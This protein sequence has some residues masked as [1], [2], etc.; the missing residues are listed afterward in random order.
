MQGNIET[1]IAPAA[2][3]RLDRALAL[4][5][6]VR[7][8]EGATAVL[9]L[10][11]VFL[12]LVCYSVIKTVREPLILLGGGA[13]VRSYAAAGQALL[14]MG[15]VPLYGLVA[16]K[17]SRLKL[18]VGVT[19]F[20][21]ACIELFALAVSARVPYVGVAFFI[22]VGIFN[23]SLV[24][25]FWS[26]ANDIYRREAGDRLFPVIMIGMTAGAPLGSIVA[27]RLF[28]AGLTP[29][30][31]L[32]VSAL[33][34]T[35][36]VGIYFLIN[37][38][39]AGTT[40]A[41]AEPLA[42][43]GGFGLVL[44]NPYLRLV[45]AL[46]VLLNIVNTTGEYVVA[47]LLTA[48]VS[49]LAAAAPG[50][51]KQAFIGAFSG[52][53]QFYVNITALL[54]Q[55]FVT[56][57]LVKF[58]GLQGA[59]LALPLIALGGYSLI[60][61]G[62][63]FTAVRWLKTA[64]NAT[65]YSIMNTARQ[66]LWL[67]T[68]R[69]E[70]YK[71]KQAVD[72]FFVRA[73]DV[74]SAMVVYAGTQL[75][76][77]GPSQF[78][79]V[80]VVLTLAWIG[81]A[82]RLLRPV[83]SRP[84]MAM[85]RLAGVGAAAAVAGVL[86]LATPASA[87]DSRADQLAAQRAEKAANLHPY[88]PTS[89]ERR[90]E[91]L[92][93]QLFAPRTLYPLVGSVFEGGGI[94]VGPGMRRPFGDTGLFSAHAAFT[95]R[96]YASAVANLRMPEFGNGRVH[97]EFNGDR[98][99]APAVA[100][101]GVGNDSEKAHKTTFGYDT[102]TVSTGARVQLFAKTSIG[103][104]FGYMDT[105]T[106][107][108]DA[109]RLALP[110]LTPSYI[111]SAVFAEFDSRTSPGYTREGGLY[112]AQFSRYAQVNGDAFSFSRVDAELQRFVPLFGD[113]QVI[114]LRATAA[115][116]F[117]GADQAVPYYLL[118]ELGG[119]H[120]LRGYSSFRFRDRNRLL[121]SG[122]YRWTAGPLADMSLFMDAGSVAPRFQDLASQELRT[123]FGVGITVHTPNATMARLEVARSREGIGVLISFGPSF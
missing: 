30:V 53:Y 70:K 96:G 9:M 32:Q 120:T 14:L 33:L 55:A 6:D 27:A 2:K 117:A 91:F 50:F 78:A 12:L 95:P 61:A 81:V 119:H 86:A 104:T 1:V 45:A 47:R 39:E 62:V 7:A 102:A 24:A 44:G 66:L 110:S 84:R 108:G 76:H 5:T 67:P 59:L 13:E 37:R 23:I 58:R 94:A 122:E 71:A 22:W 109:T 15:F 3:T 54:L 80:N 17:V 60:A 18:I 101:Y 99:H 65:D 116:T 77:L 40:R 56:S 36:S 74:V 38:R 85:P 98:I 10:V 79:M 25:Q 51:N 46:V 115:S 93:R 113:R 73:G 100:F 105:E 82:F 4:F 89:L 29:Q 28:R 8:G 72:A 111:R 83:E 42:P 52:E 16:S 64:E 34:L 31:I 90:I 121:L 35:L 19:L 21:V 43:A 11:N 63:G 123:S 69:E 92:N 103:G 112:R 48:H 68:T 75:L 20:F 118:P 114:A 106:D 88:E 26:F 57:R 41:A 107:G 49:E 87:Q 97:V